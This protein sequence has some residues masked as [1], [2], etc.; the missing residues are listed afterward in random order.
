MKPK[1]FISYPRNDASFAQRLRRR[2]KQASLSSWLDVDDLKPGTEWQ[3][4]LEEALRTA[5]A[6]VVC[7]SPNSANSAYVTCEWSYAMGAGVKVFPVLVEE[8]ALHPWLSRVQWIDL[9]G[10]RPP[11]SDLIKALKTVPRSRPTERQKTKPIQK[12]SAAARVTS[13]SPRRGPE[14]FA[15]FELKDDRPVK[16]G[17]E[18]SIALT[19]KH[20]PAATKSVTYELHD[21]SF[22]ERRF[23]VDDTEAEFEAWI[24]SYGDVLVS[25]RGKSGKKTWRA[26]KMLRKALRSG[27]G[28]QPSLAVKRAIQTIERY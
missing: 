23:R 13:A 20:A 10:K 27:H 18:Y 24:S 21:D 25:V 14:L 6:V 12:K 7:L 3:P 17:D 26:E 28:S 8:T 2:L 19:V 16:I 4:K 15:R 22:D 1:V 5:N 9:S 11:W